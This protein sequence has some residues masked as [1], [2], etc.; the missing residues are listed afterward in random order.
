LAGIHRVIAQYVHQENVQQGVPSQDINEFKALTGTGGNG[1]F[2]MV[3]IK[4]DG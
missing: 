4:H 1:Q 2:G 3:Y